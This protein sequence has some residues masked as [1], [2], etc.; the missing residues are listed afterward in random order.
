MIAW[1][2]FLVLTVGVVL[3][4]GLIVLTTVAQVFGAVLRTFRRGGGKR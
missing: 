2:W 3:F 4:I 1:P